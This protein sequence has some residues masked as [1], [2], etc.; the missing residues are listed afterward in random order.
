MQIYKERQDH[1]MKPDHL[2]LRLKLQADFLLAAAALSLHMPAK[3]LPAYQARLLV[4]CRKAEVL[5]FLH[6]FLYLSPLREL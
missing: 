6:D 2:R 5:L 1:H 4:H 3:F